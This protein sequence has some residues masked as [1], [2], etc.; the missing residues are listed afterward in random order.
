MHAMDRDPVL[1]V[2]SIAL[3]AVVMAA[4]A[5]MLRAVDAVARSAT[6]PEG[7]H[8]YGSVAEAERGL[9]TRLSLPAYFPARLRWPPTRVLGTGRGQGAVVLS[10]AAQDGGEELLVGQTLAGNGPLPEGLW[11]PAVVLETSPVDACGDGAWGGTLARIHAGDGS[12]WHEVSC[13]QAGRSVVLRSRGSTRE[14]LRMAESLR[15]E[16][17]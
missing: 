17:P 1:L 5:G 10:F 8:S 13:T 12:P 7:G 11:P 6:E 2:R 14:L 3:L 4:S 16:G 15:R 9:R